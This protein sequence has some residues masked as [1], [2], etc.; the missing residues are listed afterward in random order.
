MCAIQPR[1]LSEDV[2]P[3]NLRPTVGSALTLASKGSLCVLFGT[4]FIGG[5][6]MIYGLMLILFVIL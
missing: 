3:P 5:A 4:R 2:L 6:N 1:L